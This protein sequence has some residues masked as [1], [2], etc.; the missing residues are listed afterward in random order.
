MLKNEKDGGFEIKKLDLNKLR[1]DF[2]MTV[3]GG[4]NRGKS[5]LMRNLLYHFRK[6]P[7][8]VACSG[9]EHVAPFFRK[10]MP[11]SMIHKDFD[12][13][14]IDQI[15]NFQDTTLMRSE[16]PFAINESFALIVD[17]CG[18]DSKRWKKDIRFQELCMNGRHR[19]I[20]LMLGLQTPMAI[21]PEIREQMDA[22]FLFAPPN[23]N[24]SKKYYEH[25]ASVIPNYKLFVEIVDKVCKEHRCLV[26]LQSQ[27]AQKWQDK[28][29]YYKAEDPGNFKIGCPTFWNE[30]KKSSRDE[31]GS[32]I[33]LG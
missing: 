8:A 26:I 6:I 13:K 27:D 19:N 17:D 29:F 10:F 25:Y 5:F 18:F 9:T 15:F 7:F 14:L 4:R 1:H 20:C 16:K 2:V 23:D 28:V 33:R 11:E 31:A 32:R 3:L 21:S 22:I 12:C 30:S 24:A